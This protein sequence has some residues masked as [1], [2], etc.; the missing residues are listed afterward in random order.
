[1][2]SIDACGA[3]ADDQQNSAE[4]AR[5]LLLATEQC[6]VAVK[7]LLKNGFYVFWQTVVVQYANK[8]QEGQV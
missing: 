7:E 5:A 2:E 6:A 3:E 1:M 8:S 4:Q